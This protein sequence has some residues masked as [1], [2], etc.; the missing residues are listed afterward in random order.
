MAKCV[1]YT[2]VAI[3]HDDINF[4]GTLCSLACNF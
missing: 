1:T 3:G 2:D 4:A